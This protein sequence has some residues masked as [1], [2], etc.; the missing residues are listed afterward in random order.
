MAYRPWKNRVPR[1]TRLTFQ[2][3]KWNEYFDFF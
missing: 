2:T 1:K 3:Q